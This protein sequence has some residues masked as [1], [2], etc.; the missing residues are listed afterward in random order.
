MKNLPYFLA[1]IGIGLAAF[2]VLNAP[3]PEYATSSDT[4]EGAAR[5]TA[6][7]GSKARVTSVAPKVKGKVK[8]AI[9]RATRNPNLADE[10]LG[11]EVVG[12]LKDAAGTVAQAA[13]KTIHDLNR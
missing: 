10:G 6:N 13:G 9:G 1:A 7:W 5:D 11:D 12:Q 2:F 3:G 4:I 8:Q